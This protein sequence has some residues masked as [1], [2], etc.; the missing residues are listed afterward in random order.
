[1]SFQMSDHITKEYIK[2]IFVLLELDKGGYINI[3]IKNLRKIA[4]DLC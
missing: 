1:M 2:A 3:H 4:Q